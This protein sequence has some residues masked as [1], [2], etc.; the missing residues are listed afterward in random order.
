MKAVVDNRLKNNPGMSG[1]P[2]AQTYRDIITAPGQFAGFSSEANGNVVL[3][4]DVSNLIDTVMT[5]ANTGAPGP[6]AEFV[7]NA[8]DVCNSAVTDPFAGLTSVNGQ[9][10]TGGGYGWRTQGSSDPGG[11]LVAIPNSQGGI[12]AH[13]QFYALLT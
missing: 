13:N 8:L 4:T 11:K 5:N 1:A 10:V 9:A 6:Y 7:S 2:N 12:I 3:S